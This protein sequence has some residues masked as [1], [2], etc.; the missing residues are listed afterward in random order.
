MAADLHVLD[1][2]AL[3]SHLEEGRGHK[4]VRSLLE[5][6]QAGKTELLISD[7]NLG[8]VYYIITQRLG[9][10]AAEE[11]L[12]DLSEL[13]ITSVA[14]TWRRVRRAAKLKAAGGMSYADCFAAT[15]TVELGAAL[16][17]GDSDFKRYQDQIEIEWL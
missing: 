5:A 8:E 4:K 15:L 2:S 14:A 17:T 12:S 13:P 3:L 9:E 6:G 10:A 11:M 1:A 7:I 16:V